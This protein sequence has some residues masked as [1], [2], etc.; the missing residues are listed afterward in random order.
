MSF[1][2]V[3][4]YLWASRLVGARWALAAAVLAVRRRRSGTAAC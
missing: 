1:V 2:A 3:P 4:V